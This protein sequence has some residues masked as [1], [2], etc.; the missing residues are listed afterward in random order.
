[1]NDRLSRHIQNLPCALAPTIEER[2]NELTHALTLIRSASAAELDVN[3]AE[4]TLA[5]INHITAKAMDELYWL[6]RLPGLIATLPAPTDDEVREA[7]KG[8][9]VDSTELDDARTA[10]LQETI[11]AQN[12]AAQNAKAGAR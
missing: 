9:M 11:A 1:M 7:C 6:S 3:D 5:A 2:L 4:D 8:S 10:I 12:A